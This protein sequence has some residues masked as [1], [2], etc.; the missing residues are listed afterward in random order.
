MRGRSTADEE[1]AKRDDSS[2]DNLFATLCSSGMLEEYISESQVDSMTM[3]ASL[4]A[5]KYLRHDVD[6]LCEATLL[7]IQSDMR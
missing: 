1:G 7:S 5:D 3:A 2:D 4:D 6:S